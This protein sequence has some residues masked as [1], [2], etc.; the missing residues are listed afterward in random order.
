[1]R[2]QTEP[3][4]SPLNIRIKPEQRR[5]IERAAGAK[6]MTVSDFVRE[7]ALAEARNTLLDRTLLPLDDARWRAFVAALDAP[8]TDNP[9]LSDLMARSP[10]WE[11]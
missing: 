5:L 11:R 9:R 8:P 3:K 2:Q 7:V 1:M 4:A 10:S 6:D